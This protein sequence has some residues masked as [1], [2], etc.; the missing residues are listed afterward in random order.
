[1]TKGDLCKLFPYVSLY[2]A[3]TEY[4]R[5]AEDDELA[6]YVGEYVDVKHEMASAE[7]LVITRD[8]LFFFDLLCVSEIL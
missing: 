2:S 5:Y 3:T 1:M 8:G 6:I 7:A 4:F